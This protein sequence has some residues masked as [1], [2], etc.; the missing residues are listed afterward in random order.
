MS[1]DDNLDTKGDQRPNGSCKFIFCDNSFKSAENHEQTESFQKNQKLQKIRQ[2]NQIR[3]RIL[4]NI[5]IEKQRNLSQYI[6]NK[7][8][9]NTIKV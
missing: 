4:V 6:R 2:H 3:S 7:S 8:R 9:L 5:I 1:Q